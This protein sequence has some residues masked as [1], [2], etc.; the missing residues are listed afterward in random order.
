M[1]LEHGLDRDDDNKIGRAVRKTCSYH[2][3]TCSSIHFSWKLRLPSALLTC[4]KSVLFVDRFEHSSSPV[5]FD[6]RQVPSNA[7]ND[8]D[9][10]EQ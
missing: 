10:S 9:R 6:D 1:Q 7:R 4:S 8:N 3:L 2:C 5:T